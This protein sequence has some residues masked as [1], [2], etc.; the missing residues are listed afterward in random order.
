MDWK[1]F[2]KIEIDGV[3]VIVWLPL[4]SF[5]QVFLRYASAQKMTVDLTVGAFLLGTS[6]PRE[7]AK[8]YVARDLT[9]FAKTHVLCP[10][11]LVQWHKFSFLIS[12]KIIGKYVFLFVNS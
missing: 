11:C 2:L 5:S 4:A 7:R 1:Q 12:S 10:A 8:T 3:T 6:F 9:N